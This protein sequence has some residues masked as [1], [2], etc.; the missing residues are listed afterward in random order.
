MRHK[1]SDAS[2]RRTSLILP[3]PAHPSEAVS[4]IRFGA[5][6]LRPFAPTRLKANISRPKELL[7]LS[8]F[9]PSF[10]LCPRPSPARHLFEARPTLHFS[11][12]QFPSFL[13]S[14]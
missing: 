6:N 5:D 12:H 10:R 8:C 7:G 1:R 9:G 4:R 13:P 2:P 11:L 3:A 14:R